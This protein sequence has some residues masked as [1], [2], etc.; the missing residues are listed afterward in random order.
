MRWNPGETM[1]AQQRA[2][3]EPAREIVDDPRWQFGGAE[4][5]GLGMPL[6]ADLEFEASKMP[7]QIL[8]HFRRCQAMPSDALRPRSFAAEKSN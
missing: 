4:R 5:A 7:L 8:V 6:F 3:G 1:G 2:R